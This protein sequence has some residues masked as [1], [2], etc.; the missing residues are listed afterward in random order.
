LAYEVDTVRTTEDP[1]VKYKVT[2]IDPGG[3]YF[4]YTDK[5]GAWYILKLGVIDALYAKG[6]SGF[7]AAWEDKE[8]QS[9]DYFFNFIW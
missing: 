9:Y 6:D 8:D 4:G 3:V 5:D 7:L 2:G 1:L